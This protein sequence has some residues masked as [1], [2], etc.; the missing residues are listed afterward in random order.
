[1]TVT[2]VLPVLPASAPDLLQRGVPRDTQRVK[3][4]RVYFA[5]MNTKTAMYAT[6]CDTARQP[7]GRK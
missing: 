1:M 6:R 5:Q 4:E 7:H 2:T 3:F